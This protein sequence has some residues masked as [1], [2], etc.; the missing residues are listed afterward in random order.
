MKRQ[1]Q[2]VG[3][4]IALALAASSAAGAAATYPLKVGENRR[5]LV[6]ASGAPFFVMGD[7]PWFVQKL[8][9]EDVRMLMDDRVAKGFNTLFL[10]LLD[11]EHIPSVD[12]YGQ[13][14]FDPP[15]DVTRPVEAYWKHADAVMEEAQKRGLLV[16]QN[17]IWFGFGK[18]LWI[19]HVTPARCGVYGGF[20]AKRFARFDNLMWMHVGDRIPDAPLRACAREIA[21]AVERHA[22][23]Q[24]QTVHLQHE[25]ASATHFHGDAWLDVNLAYTYG[26]A[27]YHVLP[28]YQRGD[29]VRPV[30]LSE[31]GYEGEPNDIHL[32]PDAVRGER[33]TPFRIRRNAWWAVTSGAVGYCAGTRLWRWEPDWRET[34][35]A[36]STR[37]AP[38]LLRLLGTL[39]WWRLAPD[40]KNEFLTAG[41][42]DWPGADWAT[43]AVAD[44][45]SAAVVYLPTPRTVTVDLAKLKGRVTARWFDPTSG[46]LSPVEGSPFAGALPRELTPPA[47]NAAGEPDWVLVLR[48][49][50]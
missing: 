5:H 17:S 42:G 9:I 21:A 15:T 12:G 33:W 47:R 8:R 31:T 22:P 37:E 49:E 16:I 34:M 25:Y 41:H 3:A 10:E 23:R 39:S 7:T 35:Q 32:L 30:I 43:A 48:A 20:V 6:D 1:T 26:A 11:D 28:E 40:A 36:R 27:Y 13:R 2:A 14:A 44:D 46:E 29:P 24:L 50:P 19:H 18:G 38:L 4:L 45:G